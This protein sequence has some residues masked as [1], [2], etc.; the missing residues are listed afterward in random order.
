MRSA[1]KN[2]QVTQ[3]DDHLGSELTPSLTVCLLV[4]SSRSVS[5][6][7]AEA[8][9]LPLKRSAASEQP[10]VTRSGPW[11]RRR[12]RAPSGVRRADSGRS[13]AKDAG[14]EEHVRKVESDA[15]VEAAEEEGVWH[16]AAAMR[17][18]G[19]D[20]SREAT[21]A[22]RSR[23]VQEPRSHEDRCQ[24]KGKKHARPDQPHR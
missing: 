16:R 9:P 24:T 14:D 19:G 7:D 20:V 22:Q 18:G 13:D 4:R 1:I 8:R 3:V 21:G 6:P 11:V 17:E 15:I 10:S 23:G 5:A 12:R 2:D